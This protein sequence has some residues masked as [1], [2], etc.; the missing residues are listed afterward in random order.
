[1]HPSVEVP[2]FLRQ[3]DGVQQQKHDDERDTRMEF[4]LAPFGTDSTTDLSVMI[5]VFK[6]AVS[7][8]AALNGSEWKQIVKK[9][10]WDD[11]DDYVVQKTKKARLT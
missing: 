2:L 7:K 8:C 3:N 4:D 6:H 10:K 11:G 5:P 9:R 1:M